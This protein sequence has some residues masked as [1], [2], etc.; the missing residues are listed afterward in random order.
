MYSPDCLIT[1]PAP[2]LLLVVFVVM[3]VPFTKKK[4]WKADE[5]VLYQL[6]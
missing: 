3:V 1:P 5:K 4:F 2:L 6:H